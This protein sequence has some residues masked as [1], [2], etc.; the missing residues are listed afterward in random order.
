MKPS[1]PRKS[2]Q[3]RL[4]SSTFDDVLFWRIPY[5]NSFFIEWNYHD[6]SLRDEKTLQNCIHFGFKLDG[7]FNISGC[8]PKVAIQLLRYAAST[9]RG[10][11]NRDESHIRT[12][13]WLLIVVLGF[14][15]MTYCFKINFFVD[16]LYV[17]SF[18]M[19]DFLKI[20]FKRIAA[21]KT[22]VS[23]TCY[24]TSFFSIFS[25]ASSREKWYF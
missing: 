23:A 21:F 22:L 20:A 13:V 3:T 10:G 8:M 7:K 6:L 15:V 4:N 12:F 1:A 18:F 2:L 11:I 14:S 16:E 5:I 24:I 17:C 9:A 19:F 25:Q